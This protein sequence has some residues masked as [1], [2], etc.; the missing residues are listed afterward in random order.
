MQSHINSANFLKLF[1]H[2]FLSTTDVFRF[3]TIARV[4]DEIIP[5]FLAFD[6]QAAANGSSLHLQ[7]EHL[8]VVS[9]S[10]CF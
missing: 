2:T 10:L 9:I 4:P 7:I 5:F 3:E 8:I 6:V 1:L